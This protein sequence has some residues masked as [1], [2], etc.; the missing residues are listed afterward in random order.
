MLETEKKRIQ[1]VI[2]NLPNALASIDQETRA[3]QLPLYEERMKMTDLIGKYCMKQK[4][5]SIPSYAEASD[6]Y[7]YEAISPDAKK[8]SEEI[9][10]ILVNDVLKVNG[11]KILQLYHSDTQSK[12]MSVFDRMPLCIL[13]AVSNKVFPIIPMKKDLY[14]SD[15]W[16]CKD[17]YKAVSNPLLAWND[18]VGIDEIVDR[19]NSFESSL[20]AK[21]TKSLDSPKSEGNIKDIMKELNKSTYDIIWLGTRAYNLLVKN[22][23]IKDDKLLV[24]ESRLG[25]DILLCND[26]L[27]DLKKKAINVVE[28]GDSHIL[29]EVH[30]SCY[31]EKHENSYIRVVS[32]GNCSYTFNT[33]DGVKIGSIPL[34]LSFYYDMAFEA[35][36]IGDSK[37][38][39]VYQHMIAGIYAIRRHLRKNS[40]KR[41]APEYR[42]IQTECWYPADIMNRNAFSQKKKLS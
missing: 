34:L 32:P 13:H 14:V 15:E 23:G 42:E 17:W 3:R 6:P 38:E 19:I 20:D 18:M 4:L 40:T 25:V 22:S 37:S 5:I 24:S 27:E 29:S 1:L 31:F 7:T 12:I 8:H 41:V 36:A 21:A 30:V 35:K 28:P 26:K 2:D 9:S 16:L 10:K 39:S 11:K 33:V